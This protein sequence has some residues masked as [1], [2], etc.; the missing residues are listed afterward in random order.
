VQYFQ[1]LGANVKVFRNDA[2]TLEELDAEKPVRL[3]I[4]PGPGC[5]ADAG[6]SMDAI[7]HFAGKIPVLGVCLGHQAIVEV[8]GGKVGGAGEIMHGKQSQIHHESTG[9]FSGL[10]SPVM[11]CR[12]HSL[13]ADPAT[14]PDCLQVTAFSVRGEAASP[15]IEAAADPDSM[16]RLP[17][18]PAAAASSAT[19]T[20]AASAVVR[21]P[22]D[23]VQGVRH[24]TL[25]V[26]GVQFHPESIATQ[27]GHAMFAQFLRRTAGTW[28]KDLTAAGPSADA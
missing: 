4:S 5:P 15:P 20:A 16:T 17:S 27:G 8:F 25:S 26:E 22:S 2:I 10:P 12:Y 21:T 3:V 19:E 6:V 18:H 24:R 13:A 28:E 14:L 11:A 7:R 9:V 1:Q 23:V